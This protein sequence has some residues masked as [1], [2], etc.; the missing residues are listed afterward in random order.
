[1]SA[2]LV[3]SIGPT[4]YSMM[5]SAWKTAIVHLTQSREPDNVAII[6]LAQAPGAVS[7]LDER[8]TEVVK[9]DHRG[10][11]ILRSQLVYISAGYTGSVTK[12]ACD[13]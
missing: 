10:G 8:A 4:V 7:M 6:L 9:V 11:D 5:D 13:A 1:M 2:R 3:T 12:V